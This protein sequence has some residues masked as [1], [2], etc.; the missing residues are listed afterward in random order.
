MIEYTNECCGPCPM[1]CLGAYCRNR[2]VPHY[3]CDECGAEVE[4]INDL[5]GGICSSCKED[6]LNE[7]WE[8]LSIWEK[9]S[10]LERI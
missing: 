4:S 2:N 5:Y 3:Y 6:E 7:V 9:E 1:G 10:L 8:S